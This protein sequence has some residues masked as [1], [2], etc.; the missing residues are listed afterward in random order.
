MVNPFDSSFFKFL[1]GFI[2][3]LLLSFT[4]FYFVGKYIH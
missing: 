3:I 4:V 2:C 1:L